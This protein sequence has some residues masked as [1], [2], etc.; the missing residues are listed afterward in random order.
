MS[1]FWTERIK[2][3]EPYTP[4]EQPA[5]KKLIK[6]NTN[7]NPYPPSPLVIEAI[8]NAANEKLRLYPDPDSIQ[9]RD[10]IA[11]H[12]GL[13]REEVFPGNGSDEVLAFAFG[14]FFG[15]EEKC[16]L[17]PDISYGF[18]PVYCGL[19]NIPFT[20]IPLDE[21]FSINANSY[22]NE[23]SA[24]NCG[25]IIFPNPNAPTGILL[26]LDNVKIIAEAALKKNIVLIVDEAYIAFAAPESTVPDSSTLESS[27]LSLIKS[28]PNLLI[29]RT[30]S[31]EASLAGLRAGYAMGN[32]E[33]I[34]GLFR[35]K[36]SFN[37]YPMDA[38]SQA[39]ASA[40]IKDASYY[41]E[42]NKRIINTRTRISSA[43]EKMGFKVLP[44]SANFIFASPQKG[45]LKAADY[46]TALRERGILLR[47]F[48][49]PRI[50]N[51]LRI[52]IGNDDDMDK[53]LEACREI[54]AGGN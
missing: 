54:G 39:G 15:R 26:S 44:S 14:A 46:F 8:K 43:L 1:V 29:V 5:N 7:E 40:A 48:N 32:R 34:Q 11:G 21:D 53:F 35:M 4:G 45:N 19:W 18:Y 16:V 31:K 3:T 13:N 49:K 27:A 51:Y 50:N 38:L 17:F 37:S 12:Y 42:I 30:F 22:V 52:S 33:L 20:Q 25:G 36:D 6:L 23:I 24:G 28:F 2:N 10:I 41:R 47:Y 9:L